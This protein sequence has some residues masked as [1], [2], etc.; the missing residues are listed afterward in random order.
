MLQLQESTL[1]RKLKNRHIQFIALGGS[2]GTGLF[3]GTGSA[4]SAAG[5]AV[6]LGYLISGIAIFFIMRQLGEMDAQEPMAGSFSYFAYKYWG[7]FP[8]FIA[9]W[10]YWILYVLIGITELTAIAAYAQYWFPCLATWKTALFFFILINVINLITVKAY[11]E[12]EFWFS[13][14][15]II[16]ICAM[17]L[18]GSYILFFN[19]SLVPGASIKNLWVSTSISENSLFNGI[20]PNGL[21]GLIT[22]IPIITFAFGG[23]ELIGIAASETENPKK[24]IPKAVNQSV[25]RI[26]I[27]YIGSIV[28]LLS[29]YN[30]SKLTPDSSPFVLIFDKIGFKYMA[31]TLNFIILTA[32]LSVYNSC[33]YSNSRMLY[34]LSLQ[35]NAPKILTKTNRRGIPVHALMV[36]TILTFFVV[37]LNYFVPNW[38]D[39]FKIIMSFVVV[40]ALLSWTMITISHMKFKKQKN[41]E[42][43]TKDTMVFP[44]PLY[45]YSNYFTLTFYNFILVVMALPKLG[46]FKQVIAL[47]IWI[48]IVYLGYRLCNFK[49]FKLR[50]WSYSNERNSEYTE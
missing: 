23:L 5:P 4:I 7:K 43:Y 48:L 8:G 45:P 27:F 15:K 49:K 2:I 41:I 42:H 14:I 13:S 34:A 33:I 20:F 12:I 17:I 29:L 11:G 31:W 16:A 18:T 24:A 32:A 19:P 35:D 36:S 9:G 44:S 30:W 40:C 26:L 47:P 3:L 22:A 10:N 6:L 25:F 46:M 39:A 38:F 21:R 37:P 50:K 28:V 1:K